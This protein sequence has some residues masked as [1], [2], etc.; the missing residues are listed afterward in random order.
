MKKIKFSEGFVYFTYSL[1]FIISFST[2]ILYL[3]NVIDAKEVLVGFRIAIVILCINLIY[4]IFFGRFYFPIKIYSTFC[5]FTKR[6]RPKIY[7]E[8]QIRKFSDFGV[9]FRIYAYFSLGV[10]LLAAFAAF[11]NTLQS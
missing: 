11:S 4:V 3:A 9:W 2:L 6:L 8:N 5:W 10:V 7:G 1:I